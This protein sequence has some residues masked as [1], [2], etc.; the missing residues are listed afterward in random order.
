MADKMMRIAGRGTDGTAKPIA[1]DNEGRL[2]TRQNGYNIIDPTTVE[3]VNVALTAANPTAQFRLPTPARGKGFIVDWAYILVSRD[4]VLMNI[5]MNDKDGVAKFMRGIQLINFGT[6]NSLPLSTARNSL[7]PGWK[8][9]ED[10]IAGGRFVI[11]LAQPTVF[12]F[13]GQWNLVRNGTDANITAVM[14]AR[15]LEV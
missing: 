14:S 13:G 11:A 6:S 10:N 4:D 2:L 15:T 3:L 8:I 5:I 12:P 7:L 1:T 9:V